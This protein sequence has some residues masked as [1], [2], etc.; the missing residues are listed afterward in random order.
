MD[1]EAVLLTMV[2]ISDLH[3]YHK[4]DGRDLSEANA[5]LPTFIASSVLFDG[6]LGHHFKAMSA[7]DAFWRVHEK[8]GALLIVTGD[9]TANGHEKQF[10]AAR[11]FL[12]DRVMKNGLGLGYADWT[13]LSVSGNHDQWPGANTLC[14]A[15]TPGLTATF[16][17]KFPIVST[18][19]LSN[20][21]ELKFITIDT[22]ADVSSVS[23][24][25]GLARGSFNSQLKSLAKTLPARK[26][27]ESRILL[28]H[29][30]MAAAPAGSR[31]PT[32]IIDDKT[33]KV[34]EVFIVDHDISIV[35]SGHQHVP[36]LER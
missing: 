3:F 27:N 6:W 29:H 31:V 15:P 25:R 32:L 10:A 28:L 30:S 4:L 36:R 26:D 24:A 33:R 17:T 16:A 8:D 14:G 12:A 11:A 21:R 7:L 18:Q 20:G 2:H 23:L 34:L 22:D 35:L 13:R 1:Q 19:P 9:L 5:Q